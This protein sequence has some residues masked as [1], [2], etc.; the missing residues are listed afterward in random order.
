MISNLCHNIIDAVARLRH[1]LALLIFIRVDEIGIRLTARDGN[2]HR[3]AYLCGMR[4]GR[5]M[6]INKEPAF[7]VDQLH[8]FL[9]KV[10]IITALKFF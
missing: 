10:K 2:L 7:V 8:D 4:S 9:E 6:C 3:L 5:Q 1:L